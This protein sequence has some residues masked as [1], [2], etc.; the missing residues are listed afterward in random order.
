MGREGD[1]RELNDL[2]KRLRKAPKM[3]DGFIVE[4]KEG[5][6]EGSIPTVEAADAIEAQAKRIAELEARLDWL[7]FHFD[8]DPKWKWYGKDVAAAIRKAKTGLKKE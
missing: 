7:I 4:N 2:V 3:W 1:N 6:F 5:C 8:K